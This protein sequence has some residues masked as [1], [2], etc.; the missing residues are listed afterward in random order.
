MVLL[1]KNR[2]MDIV[3]LF[4]SSSIYICFLYKSEIV[5]F[6]ASL[7]NSIGKVELHKYLNL[8]VLIGRN[9]NFIPMYF[10]FFGRQSLIR[11]E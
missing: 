11:S 10:A 6:T 8:I 1:Y 2:M 9:L 5:L 3:C 4:G 7:N